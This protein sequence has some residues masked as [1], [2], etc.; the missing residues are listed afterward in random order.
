MTTHSIAVDGRS[1]SPAAAVTAGWFAAALAA[2]ALGAFRT[3]P[4]A[5]PVAIGLAA[6]VPP[7]VAIAFALRSARFRSWA[8]GLDLRFL[9]LLQ[10][11]RAAGLAFLA[12]AS[13]HALPAGFAIPAGVGDLFIGFTA[14]FVA[15]FAIGRSGR[16]YLAWTVLGI[17]DLVTAVTLGI[18]YS[19]SPAGILRGDIGTDLMATLPM[20]LVPAFGVPL[21]LVV[22]V[23]SLVNL[24]G[25]GPNR[26]SQDRPRV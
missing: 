1:L 18:L 2:G 25:L 19:N 26:A 17:A 22:H 10:G 13:V 21:T 23:I 5:P 16:L 24:A 9:T 12:L 11:W 15:A 20:V 7:L 4:G 14:P 3:T 8:S 6:G